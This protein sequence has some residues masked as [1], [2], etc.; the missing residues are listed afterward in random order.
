LF[1]QSPLLLLTELLQRPLPALSP[2]LPPQ[3]PLPAPCGEPLRRRSRLPPPSS[4]CGA[5]GA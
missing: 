4:S 5:S 3:S 1:P 2:R